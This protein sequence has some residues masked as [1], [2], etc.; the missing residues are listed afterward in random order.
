MAPA[1]SEFEFDI[2]RKLANG[3]RVS[4]SSTLRLRLELAGVIS[5]G[6]KGIVLTNEGRRK[7]AQGPDRSETI[8]TSTAQPPVLLDRC[9]RRLPHRRKSVF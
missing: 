8:G 3:E 6:A 2:L 7:A 1:L 9:G 5:D 4:L